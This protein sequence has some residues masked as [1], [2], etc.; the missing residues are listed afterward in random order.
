MNR[1]AKQKGQGEE[2]DWCTGAR[3]MAVPSA[4]GG[5][6]EDSTHL[7]PTSV[8]VAEAEPSTQ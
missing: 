2:H 7:N 5:S 8:V 4:D 6:R 3:P 1:Y